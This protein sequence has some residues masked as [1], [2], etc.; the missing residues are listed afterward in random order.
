[1]TTDTWAIVRTYQAGAV[2]DFDESN[3]PQ[4][5]TLGTNALK[6]VKF[7]NRRFEE[8]VAAP[9]KKLLDS[10]SSDLL[11]GIFVFTCG[12]QDSSFCE[13]VN[14]LGDTPSIQALRK[15]FPHE[16][17][18]GRIIPTVITQNWG[19]NPGSVTPL[20]A[21]IAMARDKGASRVVIWSPEIALDGL[22]LMQMKMHMDIHG[23]KLVGCMREHW[24]EK[25]Q[26]R[27]VQN[28]I[29]MWD[30]GL[31]TEIGGM[32]QDC[33]GNTVDMVDIPDIDEMGN[34]NG[35]GNETR[36]VRLAGME[37]FDA[38]IRASKKYQQ[39][40]K[41]QTFL[42]WGTIGNSNPIK[43]D[44]SHYKL[45]NKD[46]KDNLDKIARQEGVMKKYIEKHFQI[47]TDAELED[48]YKKM[49]DS[50]IVGT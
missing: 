7:D 20:N 37:D 2:F 24:Q 41:K 27:V 34:G 28:T 4:G 33:N 48:F 36:K 44:L 5:R 1:M 40:T 26:W 19:L 38:Y 43:W 23:L 32:R 42:P 31:L 29:A 17:R 11:K 16:I 9:I 21:G 3:E 30:I 14:P 39:E 25:I 49:F 50:R 13:E 12:D 15:M 22:L 8:K 6:A 18:E 47:S 35:N 10:A 46:Y 45:G